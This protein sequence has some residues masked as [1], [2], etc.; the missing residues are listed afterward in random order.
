MMIVKRTLLF[1]ICLL[2]WFFSSLIPIDLA[3]YQ[4]LKLPFFTPPPIFYSITW[5]ITY[6]GIAIS[7][8]QLII[9]FSWKYIPESYKKTLLINYIFNQLFTVVFFYLHNTFLGFISCIGTFVS[10]LFLYEETTNLNEAS[11]K[12]LNPYVLLSLFATILSLTIYIIN[13]LP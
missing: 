3:F 6:I 9:K 5:T 10:C 1:I 13:T 11:T 4:S 7:I 8:Y 2:P 12:Y